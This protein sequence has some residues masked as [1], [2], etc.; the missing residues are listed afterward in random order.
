MTSTY[1]ANTPLYEN[2]RSG[3]AAYPAAFNN[4]IDTPRLAPPE[5]QR[6]MPT[7]DNP[8][9]ST[10]RDAKSPHHQINGPL[11]GLNPWSIAF[12]RYVTFI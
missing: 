7:T 4:C 3:G 10:F 6:W 2:S 8:Y 9:P 1:D 5:H 11:D 12:P